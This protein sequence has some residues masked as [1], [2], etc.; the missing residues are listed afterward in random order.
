M[1][2][3][4]IL[5]ID[6]NENSQLNLLVEFE[7]YYKEI[8]FKDQKVESLR[9]NFVNDWYSY[10]DAIF[11][12]SMIRHSKPKKIIEV[13]SGFSSAVSMDTNDLFFNSEINLEFIEPS[14]GRLLGL[15]NE[16]DKSKYKIHQTKV[17]NLPVEVFKTLGSGDILFIDSSHKFSYGNDLYYLFFEIIPK[18]KKGVLIHFHDIFY[19]F[20][21]SDAAIQSNISWDEIYFLRNFLMFN[22]S[23]EI[24]LFSDFISK[25][26]RDKLE[27]LPLCLKNTGGNIWIEKIK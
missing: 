10:C 12:Y 23:F 8:P 7:D 22:D 25:R 6:I 18:L 3:N 13:G 9:Y 14:P 5:G 1:L 24:K 21:Y 4:E 16:N 11:L 26:H 2:E 20:K 15:M 17:E 19:P 27:K